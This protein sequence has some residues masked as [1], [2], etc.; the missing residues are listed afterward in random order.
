MDEQKKMLDGTVE[1]VKTRVAGQKH[2]D[3]LKLKTL[4]AE[5]QNRSTLV[6][7][8]ESTIAAAEGK[9]A[10]GTVQM[11][12]TT[13][14]HSSVAAD[15]DQSGPAGIAP[16]DTFD[17]SG[18]P[19]QLVPDIDPGHPAVDNDPRAN[20]TANQNRIDFNDPT[21]S[22]AEATERNLKAQA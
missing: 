9:R 8:L 6:N 14:A 17:T 10:G 21:I 22:G 12:P 11:A 16:A 19:Q 3:L 4:E 7:F 18:A 15:F 2:D 5:G 13:R 1:E 20:T